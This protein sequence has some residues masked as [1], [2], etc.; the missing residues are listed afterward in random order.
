MVSLTDFFFSSCSYYL[1]HH[2]LIT[3][4][5]QSYQQEHQHLSPFASLTLQYKYSTI[6]RHGNYIIQVCIKDLVSDY[7]MHSTKHSKWIII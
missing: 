6:L 7:I 1:I 5:L 4:N 3:E 2:Y